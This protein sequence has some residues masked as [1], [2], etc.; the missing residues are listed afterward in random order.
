[1]TY[2]NPCSK[3]PDQHLDRSDPGDETLR[4]FRY[5]MARAASYCLAL[6]DPNEGIQEVL[7]EQ[8]ED[9]LI[10]YTDGKFTGV[11][12][13]TKEDGMKPF[14]ARD[15]PVVSALK[16]FIQADRDYPDQIKRFILGSNVAFGR[17]EKN[18]SNLQFILEQ[19]AN[20]DV[21]SASTILKDFLR[22]LCEI[23][24]NDPTTEW[25]HSH[26]LSV[27]QRVV[28][29]KG[30]ELQGVEGA[31]IAQLKDMELIGPNQTYETYQAVAD[32]LI[33][34]VSEASAL[35]QG[36]F[37]RYYFALCQDPAKERTE[38]IIAAKRFDR[39]R[40]EAIIKR[41]RNT[42][43]LKVQPNNLPSVGKL[44]VG[45]DEF[46]AQIRSALTGNSTIAAA[47]TARQA[48]HGLGGIGKTRVAVEY[49]EK[50]K[51]KYSAIL[52]VEA[53]TMANLYTNF[54]SL[55][56]ARILELPEKESSNQEEQIASVLRWLRNYAGWLLIIDN[57]DTP[58]LCV[59][60]QKLI[61]PLDLGH[62]LITTRLATPG[63]TFKPL[64]LDVISE[65]AA[66]ELL[67][68][69]TEDRRTVTH[70]DGRDARALAIELGKLPLAL[71]QASAFIAT[72]RITISNYLERWKK[73]EQKV[74]AWDQKL[75]GMYNKSVL[76][77]WQVT[78]DALSSD[79]KGLLNVLCW[80]APDP[81]PV[82]M[83]SKL[84]TQEGEP[85]IDIEAGGADLEEYSF[86]RH[87][88]NNTRL[89]MH[90][91]VQEVAEKRIL[92][93]ERLGWLKRSLRMVDAFCVGDPGDVD[94]W[95][96]IYN[97]AQPHMTKIISVT[98][99]EG[100]EEQTTSLIN[101][102]AILLFTR[103]DFS[104]AEPLLRRGLTSIKIK[105]NDAKDY[106]LTATLSGTLAQIL[107]EKG[108]LKEAGEL[109]R[110]ALYLQSELFGHNTTEAAIALC[111]LGR[112]LAD[113]NELR[114]A[115]FLIRRSVALF[116]FLNKTSERSYFKA[117]VNLSSLLLQT[118]RFDEA[119]KLIRR[120]ID[121]AKQAYNDQH[122]YYGSAIAVLAQLLQTTK[123]LPEAESLMRESLRINEISFG[124][125]HPKV[126]VSL[127]NLAML[128]NAMNR[129][130][131]AEPIMRRV[132]EMDTRIFGEFHPDV[133][134]DCNNLGLLLQRMGRT[135]EAE[136]LMSNAV[137]KY[138]IAYSKDH[139]IA[140]II[141]NNIA[142]LFEQTGRLEDAF[143]VMRKSVVIFSKF[144][145]RAGHLHPNSKSARINFENLLR[146]LG[147]TPSEIKREIAGA[148]E[149]ARN[150]VENERANISL[151]SD[152]TREDEL[153]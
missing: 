111:N 78:F 137:K 67:L 22:L 18:A 147:Q 69:R 98:N 101:K 150:E 30:P 133:A 24:P 7:C 28:L 65:D 142:R 120:A 20:A 92:E 90:R 70:S 25:R 130:Q 99:R 53:D 51:D 2:K 93:T 13:K 96:T 82:E 58:E 115:E 136:E 44:C 119:E 91:L 32:A 42:P 19:A 79:G 148:M 71:E 56:G 48:I 80:L 45:R 114:D 49:A 55:C 153:S 106:Y 89:V 74:L 73:Q 40:V 17:K 144:A 129:F 83:V 11:Q 152:P 43:K 145:I 63:D 84:D 85:E 52:F 100:I 103:G 68:V 35:S 5:Q 134:R 12:I 151:K 118:S 143:P 105:P 138:E 141:F 15:E 127:N 113:A 61:Q 95:P 8:V 66:V 21:L 59:E 146:H 104:N 81:I 1:M 64:P 149:E 27:L 135:T 128:L 112:L 87:T 108:E 54:A 34:E 41:A 109:M 124:D 37:K 16:K 122:P 36:S 3:A 88:E 72:N 60:V 132:M 23:E 33:A 110:L 75:S 102:L 10:K 117:L 4:R 97:I 86:V 46:I 39:K 107:Q 77:T 140:A 57:V 26:A 29:D 139:P 116:D 94:I 50:H 131:E 9:I 123:R 38:S 14:T 121:L 47:V 125:E 31:L 126:A 6:F 62:I 76:T